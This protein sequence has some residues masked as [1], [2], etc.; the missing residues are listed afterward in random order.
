MPKNGGETVCL[1]KEAGIDRAF[2]K[3]DVA[4]E[5]DIRSCVEKSAKTYDR[6]DIR[7]F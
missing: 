5:D 1:V 3:T 2:A 6:S 4:N 7:Y